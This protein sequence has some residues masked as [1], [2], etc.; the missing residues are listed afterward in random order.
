MHSSS[1]C[2][3]ISKSEFNWCQQT[4][5]LD[6]PYSVGRLL[7]TVP[8][9]TVWSA[10]QRHVPLMMTEA[11]TSVIIRQSLWWNSTWTELYGSPIIAWQ[12]LDGGEEIDGSLLVFHPS[13]PFSIRISRFVP[14]PS[15]ASSPSSPPSLFT[16][17]FS[18]VYFRTSTPKPGPEASLTLEIV[19]SWFLSCFFGRLIVILRKAS[20]R[21]RKRRDEELF[22]SQDRFEFLLFSRFGA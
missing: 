15:A 19:P 1:F 12:K 16:F 7:Y 22:L 14:P 3:D 17:S 21:S 20:F 5:T 4:S 8:G 6:S 2:R 9:N 18:S 13:L 10:E 11:M